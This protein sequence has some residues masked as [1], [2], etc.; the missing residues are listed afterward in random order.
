LTEL[1][2]IQG[3][4][5]SLNPLSVLKRG[6]AIVTRADGKL[7]SS[8]SQVQTGNNLDVRLQDGILPVV[9]Q[10]PPVPD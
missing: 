4:L 8:I 6:Y 9:I 10:S 1:T 3:H 5:L 2:G 7:V